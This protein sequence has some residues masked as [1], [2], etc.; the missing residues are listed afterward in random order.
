MAIQKADLKAIGTTLRLVQ[1]SQVVITAQRRKI[2]P[3][4]DIGLVEHIKISGQTFREDS[5]KHER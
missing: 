3:K 5:G 2:A 1:T 4:P